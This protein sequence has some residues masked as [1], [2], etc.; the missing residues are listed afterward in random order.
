MLD[1]MGGVSA[2]T[3]SLWLVMAYIN[4]KKQ[5]G[6]LS[7]FTKCTKVD[8]KCTEVPAG[9]MRNMY[10]SRAL[11]AINCPVLGWNTAQC[12]SRPSKKTVQCDGATISSKSG[13]ASWISTFILVGIAAA[14]ASYVF[15]KMDHKKGYKPVYPVVA[16]VIVA[17]SILGLLEVPYGAGPFKTTHASRSAH[18]KIAAIAFGAMIAS[19]AYVGHHVKK[20]GLIINVITGLLA[21]CI[22]AAGVSEAIVDKDKDGIA[23]KWYLKSQGDRRFVDGIFQLGENM[24]VVLYFLVVFIASISS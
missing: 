12:R 4:V 1:L 14:S 20:Y 9:C 7:P 23:N 3:G 10:I 13:P 19:S 22:V 8:G 17:F 21:L 6:Y 5:D 18:F 2:I 16:T 24:P 11:K 15:L